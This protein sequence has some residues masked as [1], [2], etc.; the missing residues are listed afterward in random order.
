LSRY[1]LDVDPTSDPYVPFGFRLLAQ[2]DGASHGGDARI[3]RA[4]APGAYYVAVSGTGDRYFHP[5]IA[6]SGY[7]GS[8]GPYGLQITAQDLGLAPTDGPIVLATDLLINPGDTSSNVIDRSP[9]LIRVDVSAGL[10]PTTL[11]PG[12]TIEVSG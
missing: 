2:D 8:A 3:D 5:D 4:L 1:T 12:P 7:P 11:I 9:F 10:L 6:A